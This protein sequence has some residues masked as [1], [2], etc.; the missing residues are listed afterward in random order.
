MLRHAKVIVRAP[1][2][3]IAL[4]LRRM[5]DGMREAAGNALQIDKNPVAILITQ[6][7]ECRR[8]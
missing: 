3:D 2:H 6:P 7:V 8:E 4:A 1:D 5:P